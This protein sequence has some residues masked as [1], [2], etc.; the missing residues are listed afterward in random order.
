MGERGFATLISIIIA[1]VMVLLLMRTYMKTALPTGTT[2]AD[3]RTAIDAA[4]AQAVRVEELQ[5]K[6]L[7]QADP[8]AP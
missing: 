5:K 7:E 6:R 2:A 1:L 8:V 4:K 3:Q